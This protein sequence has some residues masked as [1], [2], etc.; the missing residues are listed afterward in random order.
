MVVYLL[1]FSMHLQTT[2]WWN[3]NLGTELGIRILSHC[4]LLSNE[5]FESVFDSGLASVC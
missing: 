1:T 4:P 3:E 2:V 5:V